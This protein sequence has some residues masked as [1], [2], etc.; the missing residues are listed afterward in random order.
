M[1]RPSR[2][3]IGPH[4]ERPH[5]GRA[6]MVP[7]LSLLAVAASYAV[8]AWIVQRKPAP[9]Y[10]MFLLAGI[11]LL[12]PLFIRKPVWGLL[13]YVALSCTFPVFER[14]GWVRIMLLDIRPADLVI[15]ATLVGILR[16]RPSSKVAPRSYLLPVSLL[17]I[18]RLMSYFYGVMFDMVK[19]GDVLGSVIIRGILS[20][21]LLFLLPYVVSRARL[22]SVV[23]TI[24]G[25]GVMTTVVILLVLTTRSETLFNLLV[26]DTRYLGS[27]SSTVLDPIMY[28]MSSAALQ[29]LVSVVLF[30]LMFRAARGR[31]S[32]LTITLWVL[33]S[34]S[35][36][37]SGSR[38]LILS[39][40]VGS[41][42]VV[43]LVVL[44][45]SNRRTVP[46]RFEF[47]AL[48]TP[49]V[50]VAF[51]VCAGV[52]YFRFVHPS[53]VE[54]RNKVMNELLDLGGRTSLSDSARLL[55]AQKI[56]RLLG[57]SP[58]L[59][60]FG[61]GGYLDWTSV[62]PPDYKRAGYITVTDAMGPVAMVY[63]NGLPFVLGWAW[64]SWEILRVG[65]RALRTRE[66]S[67]LEQSLVIAGIAFVP[68]W[69]VLVT[70]STVVYA[71]NL[72]GFLPL[73]LVA[74]LLSVIVE[75]KDH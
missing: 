20:F 11:F 63:I 25:I 58:S 15:A 59:L 12:A 31:F 32:L 72:R 3:A 5:S 33:I 67:G 35:T 45:S 52:A 21:T 55:S 64:F 49:L 37:F 16:H 46:L 19:F 23:L 36:A 57:E 2:L 56:I 7:V 70:L 9:S 13:T 60:L 26:L 14:M 73:L 28:N 47:R 17:W 61:Q 4:F 66:L 48:R 42:F 51:V 8:G 1:I 53:V 30:A 18:G 71:L 27:F 29:V 40:V 65:F 39:L 43:G 34:V 69:W 62:V 38:G 22:R 75:G 50:L 68:A 41:V 10:V 24:I 54:G 44:T 6:I 74:G